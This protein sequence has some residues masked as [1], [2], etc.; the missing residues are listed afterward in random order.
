MGVLKKGFARNRA[1]DHR[2]GDRKCICV[3]M[4]C[5]MWSTKVQFEPCAFGYRETYDP[6]F[7]AVENEDFRITPG[8]DNIVGF[9]K[10]CDFGRSNP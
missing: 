7:Y 3:V 8:H 2:Q 10:P 9:G 4:M 1:F 6:V 5:G